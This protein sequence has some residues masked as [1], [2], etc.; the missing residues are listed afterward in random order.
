[1]D[2]RNITTSPIH[3]IENQYNVSPYREL[4]IHTS[5]I[6]DIENQLGVTR[7]KASHGKT[8][9]NK[10]RKIIINELYNKNKSFYRDAPPT[11]LFSPAKNQF[12]PID[13]SIKK[14]DTVSNFSTLNTNKERVSS[15]ELW[16]EYKRT[17]MSPV[18]WTDQAYFPG[19][20]RRRKKRK[21]KRNKKSRK[22]RKKTIRKSKY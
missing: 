9:K 13:E 1:M 20:S 22:M 5:P 7:P 12:I 19:G 8:R 18:K 14:V 11:E 4:D 10:K 17:H 2:N 15:P 6:E 21:T 3:D 16:S